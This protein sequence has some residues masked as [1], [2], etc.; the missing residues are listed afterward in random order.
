MTYSKKFIGV[1]ILACSLQFVAAQNN[2]ITH[3]LKQ[4]ESLSAL[5]EQYHTS[6][7][8]IMRINGMHADTKLVYGSKIKIPSTQKTVVKSKQ[9]PATPPAATATS[10]EITHVVAKGETLYSISKKFNVSVDQLKA[11]NNLPDESAKIGTLLIVNEQG[12]NKL[13]S[14]P[15]QKQKTVATPQEQKET[16]A[17]PQTKEPVI[18]NKPDDNKPTATGYVTDNIQPTMQV[19]NNMS[20]PAA[21]ENVSTYSGEGFFTPQFKDKKRKDMQNVSG[22]SKTFKTA[23]G[24][25]DGKYY[26]LANDIEP[27]TIVKITADNGNSVYAKV[28]WNMGDMKENAGINFRISN[29]TAAAL[30]ENSDSFKS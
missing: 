2:Y 18:E 10:G 26:I 23:S 24:W 29:A 16:V 28:L 4:G 30:H 17:T 27:G 15:A 25:A 14:K 12:V 13:A 3:T 1:L 5:A 8:D 9:V 21:A 20:A 7:G 11:W 22:I 19:V 6:V